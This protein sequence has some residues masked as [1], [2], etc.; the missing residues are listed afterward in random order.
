M[1]KGQMVGPCLV[2]SG[3]SNEIVAKTEVYTKKKDIK[4]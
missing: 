2:H 3:L 1:S 4:L